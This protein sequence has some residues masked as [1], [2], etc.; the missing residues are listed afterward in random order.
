MRIVVLQT[1]CRSLD[2]QPKVRHVGFV[3]YAWHW[4]DVSANTTVSPRSSSTQWR[5][6]CTESAALV[7][8]AQNGLGLIFK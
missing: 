6:Y 4:D 2:H 8:V 5:S 1:P 7:P 3:A